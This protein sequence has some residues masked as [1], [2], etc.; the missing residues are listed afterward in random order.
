[1]HPEIMAI[2]ALG[3]MT[4]G[5]FGWFFSWY[6]TIGGYDSLAIAVVFALLYISFF[7]LRM[8]VTENRAHAGALIGCDLVLFLLPFIGHFSPW[9]AATAG[10]AAIWLFAAWREGR[11]QTE[12]MMHIRIK[13][14]A[15][16]FIKSTFRAVLFLSIATYL[17]LIDPAGI[18][19]S[20]TLIENSLNNMMSNV[21]KGFMEQVVGRE[22]TAEESKDAINRIARSIEATAEAVIGKVP[23]KAKSGILVGVGIVIFL[24]VSSFINLLI[25]LVMGFVWCVLRLLLKLNFITITTEKADKETIVT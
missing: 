25:P 9:L 20:R 13:E 15:R 1:M 21:N 3:A 6:A 4:A 2:G 18:A 11:R 22:I 24:L 5:A 8:L 17:S 12:N 7:T 14:L 10:I 16:G 23:P 19:V